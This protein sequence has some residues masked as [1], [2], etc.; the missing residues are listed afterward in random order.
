MTHIDPI[1]EE[2]LHAYIDEQL[3]VVRRV[4]VEAFLAERPEAAA[5]VMADLRARDELRLALAPMASL[6]RPSTGDAARRID[7]ALSRQAM[8]HRFRP[9]MAAVVLVAAGW[10][11]HGVYSPGTLG[12]NAVPGYVEAA[13]SARQTSLLRAAMFSQPEAPDYDRAELLSAT[14][15][16][17]PELPADW[18]VTDVQVFPSQFG[19]SIEMTIDAVGYG[20]L[21]LF[22]ARPGGF[23]VSP[24][25]T[26]EMDDLSGAHWQLGE[27]AYAL[28]GE[29]RPEGLGQPAVTLAE[30]LY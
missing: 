6:V 18:T 28:L 3:D 19:P 22:A 23:A 21:S 26:L 16:V 12:A 14:A 30:T 27:V 11:A 5:R 25:S 29:R 2:D 24:V 1:S 20:T 7:A 4:E 9:A 10:L 15:I 17:T 13:L 8:V